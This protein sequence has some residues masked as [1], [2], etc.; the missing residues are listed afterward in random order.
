MKDVITVNGNE[1]SIEVYPVY[2]GYMQTMGIDIIEGR[3]FLPS[4]SI[5]GCYI[6]NQAAREQWDWVELGKPLADD[7]SAIV[8]GVCE[9][10]RHGTTRINNASPVAF[11]LTRYGQNKYFE[12]RTAPDADQNAIRGQLADII[13]R[14]TGLEP[15]CIKKV[16]DIINDAY[17]YEFRFIRHIL[18]YSVCSIIIM[19]IGVFCLTLFETEFRRKEIGIRKVAGASSANIIMMFYHYYGSLIP[20]SFVIS[21]PLAYLMSDQ[22]L[23]NFA[24]HTPFQWWLFPLSLLVVG[25]L[26]LA[27]EVLQCWRA[28]HENPVNCL[29]DE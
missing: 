2:Y 8:V 26:A 1:F 23:D 22:W 15:E 7:G 6:I 21:V 25:A 27:T 10:I 20:I 24:E 28:A 17:Y 19:L 3:D 12:V 18:L 29:R 11:W 9:N 4:D 14:H 5:G 13:Q 16:D